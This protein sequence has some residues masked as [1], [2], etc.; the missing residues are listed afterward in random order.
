MVRFDYIPLRD[1][2]IE[3][4]EQPTNT[5]L[6]WGDQALVVW[7]G[8]Q[9]GLALCRS[10]DTTQTLY[11]AL[12][13]AKRQAALTEEP[14][15]LKLASTRLTILTLVYEAQLWAQDAQNGRQTAPVGK[16]VE[17]LG[18]HVLAGLALERIV[19]DAPEVRPAEQQG[20][21]K[22]QGHPPDRKPSP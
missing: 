7:D 11:R 1:A 15:A 13:R 3:Q 2:L 5:I 19:H 22:G 17:E 12:L 20:K 6:P 16:L 4:L 9:E 18:S 8:V 10:A 21:T 14:G